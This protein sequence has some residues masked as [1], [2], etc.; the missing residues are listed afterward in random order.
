MGSETGMGTENFLICTSRSAWYST[1]EP[2]RLRFERAAEL[3]WERHVGLTTRPL[4]SVIVPTHNRADLLIDRA[5]KSVLAQTHDNLEVI[6][7]AHGCTDDTVPAL[8]ALGDKRIRV[9]EV[10]R[11][12]KYPPTPENHWFAGPVDPL[13]AALAECRGDW[14][15]RL[16][17]DDAWTDDHLRV[18]LRFARIGDYEFVSSAHR[19]HEG[20]VEPYDLDGVKVG[21]SKTWLY[22]DY[23]KFMRYNPHCW[24]KSWH[25]VN[26]TDLQLRLRFAGVRM[27]YLPMVTAFVLPRP[28]EKHVGLKAYLQQGTM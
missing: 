9:I 19:T 14:I 24:R 3:A 23:L 2:I 20:W 26:D 27:A 5:L 25:K 11:V 12:V 18:L 22:R 21:G 16:D 4:V 28:G 13:N 15:A 1:Y 6:V 8:Y 7:A 17:D 10:P